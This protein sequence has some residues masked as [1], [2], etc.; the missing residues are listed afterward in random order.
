MNTIKLSQQDITVVHKK[1][2]INVNE[3]TQVTIPINL[4][5]R[6]LK[7]IPTQLWHE[8]RDEFINKLAAALNPEYYESLLENE[9][10]LMNFIAECKEVESMYNSY[11]V[12]V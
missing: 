6:M 5:M 11:N 2:Q 10:M 1:E 4:F 9:L 12:N 7:Y 3:M 8:R